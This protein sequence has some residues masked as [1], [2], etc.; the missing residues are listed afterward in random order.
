MG[1]IRAGRQVSPTKAVN[2]SYTTFANSTW[3]VGSA[4]GG[5]DTADTTSYQHTGNAGDRVT[6]AIT[7]LT[8]VISGFQAQIQVSKDTTKT[9]GVETTRQATPVNAAATPVADQ[10]AEV[11]FGSQ[12]TAATNQM[13]YGVSYN[14]GALSLMYGRADQ[15][16]ISAG[17][18]TNTEHDA[19][20]VSYKLGAATLFATYND[21][22][23]T[24]A[25]V[26]Q[27]ERKDTTIGI[28]YNMGKWDL[29]AAYAEGEVN[30]KVAGTAATATVGERD[31]KGYQIGAVYNLSKR[32]NA[33]VAYGDSET[34]T[35]GTALTSTRDGY[36]AGVRHSF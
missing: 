32:T 11:L 2:D 7:F 3:N 25:G 14:A 9:D 12:V 19:I 13:N 5:V 17:V 24:K 31:I 6:N 15:D 29:K 30:Q 22:A 18:K 35:K 10:V 16:S 33:Y 21:K 27:D 20:G 4:T 23:V 36:I 8:P 28:N 26:V 1:S 34:K